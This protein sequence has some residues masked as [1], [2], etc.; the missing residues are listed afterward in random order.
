MQ[1]KAG[2]ADAQAEGQGKRGLMLQRLPGKPAGP[3]TGD[4]PKSR[5]M[6]A[7]A[8]R[9][10]LKRERDR[11]YR[12][13][14]KRGEVVVPVTIGPDELTWLIRVRWLMPDEAD[15]G[16]PRIIGERIAAGLAASAKG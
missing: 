16:D 11:A 10:E 9:R 8:R 7:R 6:S 15:A 4:R 5:P 14:I 2:E 3:S 13:R 1:G 12:R